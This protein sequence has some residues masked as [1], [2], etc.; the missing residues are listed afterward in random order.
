MILSINHR[1]WLLCKF[2]ALLISTGSFF[3]E[4]TNKKS[5]PEFL[6]PTEDVW[7]ISLVT[8]YQVIKFWNAVG[9][10]EYEK[11]KQY[12]NVY[13]SFISME[14][15]CFEFIYHY[16]C[17]NRNRFKYLVS[18]SDLP[19]SCGYSFAVFYKTL[20]FRTLKH[21]GASTVIRLWTMYHQ[22]LTNIKPNLAL[23]SNYLQP[24]L[25]S[26]VR[27]NYEGDVWFDPVHCQATCCFINRMPLLALALHCGRERYLKNRHIKAM[28][29]I[30]MS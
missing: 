20:K 13:V 10:L 3:C 5:H 8:P 26:S 23:A 15:K 16:N 28:A 29:E 27:I 11:W 17:E 24:V 18:Y 25:N 7:C 19:R 1:V 4:T 12:Q 21:N 6:A 14:K 22:P 30:L 9:S 2:F